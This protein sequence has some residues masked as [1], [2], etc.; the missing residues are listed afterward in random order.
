MAR[1]RKPED[2]KLVTVS[3]CLPKDVADA[4]RRVATARRVLP[5]E[6]LRKLV[7]RGFRYRENA[8][9]ESSLTL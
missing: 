5:S 3:T 6:V 1:P 2:E 7:L 9:D 4:I 8:T